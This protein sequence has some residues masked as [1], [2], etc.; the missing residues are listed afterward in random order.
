MDCIF[1]LVTELA[2]S[3]SLALLAWGAALCVAETL[4]RGGRQAERA[5]PG[6]A[7]AAPAHAVEV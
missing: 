5:G 4:A 7:G 1:E 3:G 6:A 2:I